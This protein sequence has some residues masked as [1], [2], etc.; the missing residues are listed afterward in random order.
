MFTD[1]SEQGTTSIFKA[2]F[3]LL[4]DFLLD[5]LVDIEDGISSFFRNVGEPDYRVLQP[6]S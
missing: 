2:C 4:A 5:L 1:V 3:L 6:R